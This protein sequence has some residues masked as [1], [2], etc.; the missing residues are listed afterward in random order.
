MRP[1]T[2][3]TVEDC[4][5]DV[6]EFGD[7]PERQYYYVSYSDVYHTSPRCP[8]IQQ[9]DNLDVAGRLSGLNGPY[10]GGANRVISAVDDGEDID[11]C[12]WCAENGS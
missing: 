2:G 6:E 7:D 8:H 10:R 1:K 4:V 5:E 12:S 3:L 11:Q 9:S